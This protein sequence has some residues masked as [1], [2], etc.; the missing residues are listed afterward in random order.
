MTRF[1]SI[2]GLTLSLECDP[3]PHRLFLEDALESFTCEP[4]ARPDI[5]FRVDIESAF[6]GLDAYKTIFT[7]N[8]DGLWTILEDMAKSHYLIALQNVASDKEPYRIIRADRKFSDF[9]I[10]TRPSDEGVLY[11]LEYPL[12]DLAV[13]GHINI[14]RIGIILHSAC[15]ST[16]GRGLLFSGVS[17]AGKSTISELW[18]KDPGSVV[19][20]DERVLIREKDADLWA[21][22]TPWHGTSVIHKNLGVPIDRVFFI[23]HGGINRIWPLSRKDA[24]NRLM[25]RCFPTF[26]NLDGMKFALDFC[27]RVADEIECGELSFIKEM[28]TVDFLKKMDTPKHHN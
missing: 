1:Y 25:V 17:G 2:G 23:K 18:Q 28:S 22:G 24:A 8:P 27:L 10:Y 20:T 21:Y 9:H 12:A 26:W 5:Q 6:P 15:V 11:P 13:S 14:N 16:G 4:C 3:G 19:L 7:S